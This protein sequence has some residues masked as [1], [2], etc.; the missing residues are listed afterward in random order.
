MKQN[1]TKWKN[2]NNNLIKSFVI[3]AC[4]LFLSYAFQV[5]SFIRVATKLLRK[6]KSMILPE[7]VTAKEVGRV[8]K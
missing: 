3:R 1:S 6:E 8:I 7:Y 5:K 4:T 2:S